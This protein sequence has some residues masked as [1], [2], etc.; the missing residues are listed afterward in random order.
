[1]R[2]NRLNAA[3]LL[4]MALTLRGARPGSERR[5]LHLALHQGPA[6]AR[7]GHVPVGVAQG[8]RRRGLP[9]GRRRRRGLA[10]LR[11]HPRG[12]EGGFDRQ[13]GASHGFHRRPPEDLGGVVEF[14][15]LLHLRCRD[16]PAPPQAAAGGR[17]RGEDHGPFRAAHAL[18]DPRPH[19]G[20]HGLGP[21]RQRTRWHRGIHQRRR[22][23]RQLPDRE[24]SL[25]D[26]DQ[27]RVQPDDHLELGAAVD[28]HAASGQLEPGHLLRHDDRLGP[29]GAQDRPGT[30]GRRHPA[31]GALAAEPGRQDRVQHHGVRTRSGSSGCRTTVPSPT[32]RRPIPAPAAARATCARDPTTSTSTSAARVRARSRPGTFPIPTTSS[33]TTPSKAW[34][35]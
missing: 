12:G 4:L 20:Q 10:H 15:P 9:R 7:E 24:Q 3:A 32:T 26:R 22:L 28:L 19:P 16:R 8:N 6:A 1:M 33:C 35:R 21:G 23:H 29:Q 14:Q 34:S 25:R 31:G 27:A 5:D 17:G 30:E 18:R 2:S 13:R 11:H